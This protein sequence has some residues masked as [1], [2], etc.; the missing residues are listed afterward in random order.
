MTDKLKAGI[1]AELND[2][3]AERERLDALNND[4]KIQLDALD[5]RLTA[6]LEN[7]AEITARWNAPSLVGG[8]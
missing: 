5:R 3:D 6:L 1:V 7:L 4:L 8:Y 2:I